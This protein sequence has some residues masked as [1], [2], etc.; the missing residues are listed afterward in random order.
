MG[1]FLVGLGLAYEYENNHIS[2]LQKESTNISRYLSQLMV[3]MIRELG[4][5]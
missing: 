5:I 3:P 4:A 2:D 1:M